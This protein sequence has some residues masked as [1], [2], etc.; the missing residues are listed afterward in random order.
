[1]IQTDARVR[2]TNVPVSSGTSKFKHF[3]S[4]NS[5]EHLNLVMLAALAQV[6]QNLENEF[7]YPVKNKP[8]H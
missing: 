8:S 3:P 6:L 2:G 5:A 4:R 7:V 1:M